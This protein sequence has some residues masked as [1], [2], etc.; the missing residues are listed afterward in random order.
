VKR[1]PLVAGFVL[2]VIFCVSVAQWTWQLFNPTELP[3]VAQ[4]HVSADSNRNAVADLFS[5]RPAAVAASSIFQLKGVVIAQK[6]RGSIAILQID[7]KPAQA[8]G[9]GAEV[10]P[11]VTVSE[12]HPQYVLLVEHGLSKRVELPDN[13]KSQSV[14]SIDAPMQSQTVPVQSVGAATPQISS[15]PVNMVIRTNAEIG[16]LPEIAYTHADTTSIAPTPSSC[17]LAPQIPPSPNMLVRL[18]AGKVE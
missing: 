11:G 13:V 1:W 7:G 4:Q 3:A 2:F 17:A 16:G 12:V 6:E 15:A 18:N 5:V 14:P 9:V 10:L 8:A